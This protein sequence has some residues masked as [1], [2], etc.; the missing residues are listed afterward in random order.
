MLRKLFP[1]SFINF[2]QFNELVSAVHTS[3]LLTWSNYM[4]V[5]ELLTLRV[6]APEYRYHEVM[7]KYLSAL[8]MHIWRVIT[9]W[10][11]ESI[12]EQKC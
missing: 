8:L 9:W 4:F 1:C 11:I 2:C 12:F 10:C 5:L 6:I 7:I 3:D